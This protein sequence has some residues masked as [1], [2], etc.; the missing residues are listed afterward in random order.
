M[1]VGKAYI[2]SLVFFK[3]YV[4]PAPKRKT[5]IRMDRDEKLI[6]REVSDIFFRRHFSRPDFDQ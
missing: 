2:F 6:K 3:R 5:K 4:I 1:V